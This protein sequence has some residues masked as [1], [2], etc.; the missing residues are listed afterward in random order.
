MSDVTALD[1]KRALAKGHGNNEFFITECKNGPTGRGMLQFD[2]LAIYKSWTHPKIVGYEI[3]VSRSDF[4]RDNKFYLYMPYVHEL[5]FVVPTGLIDRNELPN[6]IG[7][8]YYNPDKK[9]LL[10]KKK[11]TYQKI[12]VSSEMLLY[13]IMNR[14][15][16]ERLPFTSDKAE[17]FRLW[18]QGKTNNRELGYQVSCKFIEELTDK[19]RELTRYQRV[20]DDMDILGAIEKIMDKHGLSRWGNRADELDKALT[21][22]YPAKLDN[23]K[24]QL[25]FAINEINMIKEQGGG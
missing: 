11:A 6:E 12:E 14:L 8:I 1:I 20:K 21:R 13:I 4:L 19:D 18:V 25:E 2:G 22:E 15:D 23:I 9:T 5:Y 16:S 3:K 17:Y 24:R 10:T 7:L